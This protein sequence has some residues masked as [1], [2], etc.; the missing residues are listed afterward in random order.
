[1]NSALSTAFLDPFNAVFSNGEIY[2]YAGT[3]PAVDFDSGVLFNDYLGYILLPEVPFT[4]T[5]SGTLVK[6]GT[7]EG[8][9]NNVDAPISWFRLFDA[10]LDTYWIDGTASLT[11]G[12]GELQ[13]PNLNIPANAAITVETAT[14]Q[15]TY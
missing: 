14:F 13:F 12:G 8:F 10:T 3:R 4:A 1:M 6:N 11:G 5:G 7:W 9:R 15:F 2:L